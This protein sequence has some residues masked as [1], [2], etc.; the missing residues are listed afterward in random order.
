MNMNLDKLKDLATVFIPKEENEGEERIDNATA[1]HFLFLVILVM[2]MGLFYI[3]NDVDYD[4]QIKHYYKSRDELIDRRYV[5]ISDQKELNEAGMRSSVEQ[6]LRERGSSVCA[7][8]NK[9]VVI[10]NEETD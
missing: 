8:K 2:G 10:K 9:Q 1:S 5:Y 3:Y 6:K 4:L 7:P